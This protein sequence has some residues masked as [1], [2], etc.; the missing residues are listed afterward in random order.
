M[1]DSN[2]NANEVTFPT[3]TGDASTII[4][5]ETSAIVDDILDDV[6]RERQRQNA[7][8]AAG[9]FKYTPNEVPLTHSCVMLSEEVGEVARGA[10]AV[11]GYVQEELTLAD[12]RKELVQV[13]AIAVAMI[14]GIDEGTAGIEPS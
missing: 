1:T 10:L 2:L 12:V 4:D 13:A 3:C 11:G 8:K 5:W 6:F 7:L 9:R 14:Q